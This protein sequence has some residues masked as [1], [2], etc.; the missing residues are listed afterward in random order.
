MHKV[1]TARGYI[2]HFSCDFLYFARCKFIYV[3]MQ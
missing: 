3:R 1:H 2:S